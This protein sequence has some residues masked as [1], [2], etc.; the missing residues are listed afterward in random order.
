[1]IKLVAVFITF[2]ISTIFSSTD[3]LTPLPK[4][5]IQIEIGIDKS[6]VIGILDFKTCNLSLKHEETPIVSCTGRIF[7]YESGH[8]GSIG[9]SANPNLKSREQMSLITSDQKTNCEYINLFGK[10]IGDIPRA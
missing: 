7:E 1:M 2:V 4:S 10:Q 3:R 6:E 5:A 9:L 8:T